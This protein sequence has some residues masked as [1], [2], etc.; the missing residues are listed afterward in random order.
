MMRNPTGSIMV[1]SVIVSKMSY[2]WIT[3]S[4]MNNPDT[5]EGN[6]VNLANNSKQGVRHA[7]RSCQSK[8]STLQNE[9]ED[10]E[11]VSKILY[12]HIPTTSGH[13]QGPKTE[14]P[15]EISV[16]DDAQDDLPPPAD[17]YDSKE[18]SK[19][20]SSTE[21]SKKE[22]STEDALTEDKTEKIFDFFMHVLPNLSSLDGIYNF[23]SA[24]HLLYT[25]IPVIDKKSRLLY[26]KMFRQAEL[27]IDVIE[28][29]EVS[30]EFKDLPMNVHTIQK[31]QHLAEDYNGQK[32][33]FN[34]S[35]LNGNSTNQR[36][37]ERGM[38]ATSMQQAVQGKTMQNEPDFDNSYNPVLKYRIEKKKDTYKTIHREYQ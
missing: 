30:E 3:D 15:V 17:A 8:H 26:E 5:L 2:K 29:G 23:L 19:K 9:D 24:L 22:S 33:L 20:E 10:L 32:K 6:V 21:D 35:V 36:R 38:V 37:L 4:L 25:V 34:F 27:V 7:V 31:M 1:Y 14:S 16:S 11:I 13:F 18:D 12:M 28:T